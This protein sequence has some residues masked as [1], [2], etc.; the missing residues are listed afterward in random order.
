MLL[1]IMVVIFATMMNGILVSLRL[2]Y[3][4]EYQEALLEYIICEMTA[5]KN[6]ESHCDKDDL[7]RYSFA[8]SS[9]VSLAI[10]TVLTPAFFLV[11]TIKWTGIIANFKK[12]AQVM[13]RKSQEERYSTQNFRLS[14]IG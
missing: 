7:E 10:I 5:Y 12:T 8:I 1:M 2:A 13:C 6:E 11:I 4:D 14:S 3:T 9:A